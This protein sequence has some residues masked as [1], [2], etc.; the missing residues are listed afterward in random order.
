MAKPVLV[1][2][3][4]AWHSPAHFKPLKGYLEG[5]GYNCVPVKL[6]SVIQNEGDDVPTSLELDIHEVRSTVLKVLDSGNN[7]VVLAHSYGGLPTMSALEGLDQKSRVNAGYTNC[8]EAIACIA[9]FVL[10]VGTSLID[11]SGGFPAPTHDVRGDLLFVNEPGPVY[12]FYA[13]LPEK[14]T[15]KWVALLRPHSW[16]VNLDKAKFAAYEAIPTSYLICTKDAAFP[17][18]AQ[19]EIC[20]TAS[21]GGLKVRVEEIDSSHSPFLSMVEKTGD[22]VRRSAGENI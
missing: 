22:F 19:R 6:P 13:D 8:V 9:A 17:P 12:W 3:H 7:A 16:K 20:K 4:G 18:E 2:V 11:T 5:V 21:K 15:Q 14:E 1:L 10:P